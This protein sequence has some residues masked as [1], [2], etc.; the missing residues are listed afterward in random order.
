MGKAF[1]R[2][3]CLVLALCAMASLL[4][5]CRKQEEAGN[6]YTYHIYTGALGNNWNPHSWQNNA[7]DT[8]LEY[9]SMPLCTM[10]VKNSE[11]G[12]YQWA[13]EM[14]ESITD[15]TADNQ[16]DLEIYG[17]ILPEGQTVEATTAG[18]V[19]EIRLN[20]QAKWEDGTAINADSYIYSMQQLLDPQMRNY[21]ANLYHSGESAVAGGSAYYNSGAPIYRPMVPAY[22]QGSTPDY[23]F[24]LEKGIGE[25]NVYVNVSTKTMTL[26]DKSL[27]AL[28][29]GSGLESILSAL[30]SQADAYGY[31]RV[32]AENRGQVEQVL[33]AALDALDISQPERAKEALFVFT[34]EYTEKVDFA[35]TVGCYKVD[36]YTIRYVTQNYIDRDY[37]LTS[38]TS[39]WLVYAPYYEAGKDTSGKLVTTN[40]GTNLNNT[41][42]YGPYKLAS[43]QADKQIVFVQNENW[44]GWEPQED[45]TLVSYTDFAVDGEVQ[46]QY[47]TT[48]I[49]IDVMDDA[50][51]KQAFLKGAL[52]EWTPS[53][54]DLLTYA[55]SEQLYRMDET[56]T[57]SLFFNT[58]K[59]TLQ[60]M[61]RAKGNTNSV[62]LSNEDFRK[63]MSLA[64][65][66][67]ELATATAGYKPAYALL[68]DLYYYDV[69]NDPTSSYRG[70]REAMESI[71]RLYDVAY[72]P[73]TPYATLEDAYRSINGYNLPQARTLMASACAQLTEAGD[74]TPGQDIVIRV[75]WSAGAL[76]T[77]ANNMVE[78]MNRYLNAAAEGSGFG[79]ITLEPVG[80][81][82]DRYGDV[83]SGEYAIG[84]GAW[85]GAAFYPFRTMQVYLDP[86]LYRLHEAGSWDPRVES[87]T[88]TVSGEPVTMTW[89]AWSGA[90]IGSGPYAQAD[91]Q[92]KL[93]ITAQLE[94]NFLRKYYRIPL[95]GSTV[96]FMQSYQVRN[97]TDRYNIMYDFGGLRLM[98]YNYTDAQWAEYVASQKGTLNYQ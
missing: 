34:G 47:Q 54:D 22:E 82:T 64:I 35:T 69:Y 44:Y 97:Y 41:M 80:N 91:N 40:Y 84:Y 71:C 62:V 86:D 39:N 8:I 2:I 20:P 14:A 7:D 63:A 93:A 60:Q 21:R 51:A 87:L 9:L 98:R 27:G 73:G 96:C 4:G 48:R 68:N 75:G 17:V 23:S 85:G 92:V 67:E 65:N 61:D 5:G 24:D 16:E 30:E 89:Q 79:R 42:S 55:T 94:E 57:M 25:G 46:Q 77:T 10:T 31:T 88:L 28:L 53:P 95:A 26:S 37:F 78:L 33:T 50:A 83:A 12:E 49:V 74:Y 45:G 66:R 81:I 59:A 32:T 76:D 11:T 19:Y 56:Y 18:Y 90:L 1:K 13:F 15:V 58:N 3:L 6:T 36:D 29:K 43:L 70:S 72:G 38:C 52:S